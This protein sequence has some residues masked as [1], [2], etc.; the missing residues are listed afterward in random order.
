[1]SRTRKLSVALLDRQQ[2][3]S[4]TQATHPPA[5]SP[6]C[7]CRE[8]WVGVGT[9][10][11]RHGSRHDRHAVPPSAPGKPTLLRAVEQTS[12]GSGAG[13]EQVPQAHAVPAA[14]VHA[15]APGLCPLSSFASRR[16][17]ANYLVA[18]AKRQRSGCA[19][20]LIPS[21]GRLLCGRLCPKNIIK[22]T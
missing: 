20:P 6:S 19:G 17:C 13:S 7:W 21:E 18:V 16:V 12:P 10:P 3:A 15:A 4:H 22:G 8:L 2:L 14:G 11:R 1:M 9:E 5:P